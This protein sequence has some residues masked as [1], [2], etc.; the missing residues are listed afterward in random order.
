M[1]CLSSTEYLHVDDVGVLGIALDVVEEVGF[2]LTT[3][4]RDYELLVIHDG[5]FFEGGISALEVLEVL[6]E[7]LNSGFE[8][9]QSDLVILHL[10]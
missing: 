9:A 6:H 3:D 5:G 8:Y 7:G 2:L 10:R 4:A 1:K